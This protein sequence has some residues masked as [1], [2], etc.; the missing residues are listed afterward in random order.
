VKK[1]IKLSILLLVISALISLI[2]CTGSN[3]DVVNI[4]SNVA[5]SS[6]EIVSSDLSES[7]SEIT[8]SQQVQ[9]LN[10]WNLIFVNPW[11]KLPDDFEFEIGTIGSRKMDKRIVANV[12]KMFLDAK[13][14]GI[15]LMIA[16]AY[17]TVERQTELFNE[18]IKS[19]KN[20]GY[21]DTD[22]YNEAKQ[23]VAI[24][25][26]SEHHTGLA[27][28]IVT[29]TYQVL[30]YGF[31]TTDAFKWLNENCT[32]YG[33]ILRYP[34]GKTDITGITYEPWHYRYVGVEIAKYITENNLTFEEYIEEIS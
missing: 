26:T 33:F 16:S 25:G 30:N 17:R 18:Q 3:K 19:Y 28:D 5:L 23:W 13:N 2:S 1:H 31:D 12:E 24:P 6:S 11:N 21:S 32:E 9:N 4:Q 27:L 20:Q 14:D 7:S 10:D 29:P 34:K 22:A 15:D 8:S